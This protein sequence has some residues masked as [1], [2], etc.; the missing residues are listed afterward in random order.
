MRSAIASLESERLDG[1]DGSEEQ[2]CH[3]MGLRCSEGSFVRFAPVERLPPLCCHWEKGFCREY[4]TLSSRSPLRR[5]HRTPFRTGARPANFATD[6]AFKR[7]TR[8]TTHRPAGA[9]KRTSAFSL[10]CAISPSSLP[11]SWRN[12]PFAGGTCCAQSPP[13]SSGRYSSRRSV[14][15][16]SRAAKSLPAY[17]RGLGVHALARTWCPPL[18]TVTASGRG[19]AGRIRGAPL[20]P[21]VHE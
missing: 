17:V 2:A 13:R 11:V 16:A 18:L 19:Q 12:R 1:V 10:L 21:V 7:L 15:M 3:G 6:V 5:S 14:S 8:A 9:N 20:E 4:V